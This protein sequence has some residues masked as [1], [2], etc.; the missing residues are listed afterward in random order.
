MP[1]P[2][3]FLCGNWVWDPILKELRYYERAGKKWRDAPEAVERLK[4]VKS[5]TWYRWSQAPMASTTG[6]MMSPRMSRV[7]AAYEGG[8][9]L[10]INEVE[11][12]CAGQ[13][14]EAL[15]G[16][17]GLKV[18]HA[19]APT[20]RRRGNLPPRDSMGRLVD[21]SGQTETILDETAG[22]VTVTT[23]KRFFGKTRRAYRLSEI[24]RLELAYELRDP[25]ER[26]A[27]TALLGPEEERVAVASYEGYE[28][29][30]DPAEWPEFAAD[31][32][33]RLG[34]QLLVGDLPD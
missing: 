12:D 4:P 21:R 15:A 17:F 27:L 24:R 20:G 9:D 1:E 25:T 11:R 29:W 28:G 30:A 13:L 26:Y 14:A 8:G 7:V 6:Q 31:V 32:A 10:T 5:V 22:E 33:Q 16:A 19:G 18:M 34:V 2:G 23:R 3:E